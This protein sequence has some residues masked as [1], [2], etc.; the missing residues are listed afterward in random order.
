[1]IR[2]MLTSALGLVLVSCAAPTPQP[3]VESL[4]NDGRDI[5][6]A[7]CAV[8]HAVDAHGES[9]D[10]A[11]PHFRTILKR[12][13]ADVLEEELITGIQIA[14]PMPEFHINPQGVDR[15]IAYI[16]SIQE[17]PSQERRSEASPAPGDA[18]EGRQ[19]AEI[20]CSTC[21]AIGVS[22]EGRHPVAPSFRTL[23]EHYPVNALE[24][25][26]AEGVLVGH[27]DMPEFQ[28]EPAQIDDLVVYL[29]S[30]Q[31]RQGG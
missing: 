13:S 21:H 9:P 20:Y 17:A 8:C 3:V 29:N 6:V 16:R 28:L 10:P 15:L 4:E 7:Q 31:T 30:I 11:A 2:S 24:E 19:L 27:R 5:A 14:H 12:Y 25:A 22:G 18:E 23:S 26:F 1:M